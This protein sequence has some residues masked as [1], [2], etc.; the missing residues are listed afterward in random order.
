MDAA[1]ILHK[2]QL[3]GL[4]GE[5]IEHAVFI[6]GGSAAKIYY[7]ESNTRTVDLRLLNRVAAGSRNGPG[8]DPDGLNFY[9]LLT[10]AL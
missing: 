9:T 3:E 2:L 10:L 4:F 7:A 5:D 1:Q 6:D 8:N